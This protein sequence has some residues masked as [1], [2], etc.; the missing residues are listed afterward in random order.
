MAAQL[1]PNMLTSAFQLTK[2][3]HRDVYPAIDPKKLAQLASDKVIL[4]TGAGG[5]IGYAV[6]K[7]WTEVNAKGVVLVGRD[8]KKLSSVA[9]EV[10][11]NTLVAAGDITKEEDV[12][13]IFENAIAKFGTVDVVVNAAGIF[14]Y[15]SIGEFEPSQ[16]W[17]D[18]EINVK[19]TY[20]LAQFLHNFNKDRTATFINLVSI[21]A[22]MTNSGLSS[23]TTSQLAATKLGEHLDLELSNLRV[24]SI[25]PGIV[26]AKAGRGAV[27]DAMTPFAKDQPELTGAFT[28]YLLKP[29]ADVLRGGYVSVNWDVE[30]IRK[31]AEEI[32]EGKLL[33]LGH[34]N[35]KVG[36]DG[37][38]WAQ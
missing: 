12:K 10:E 33:R 9:A 17:A 32:K 8:A 7:T 14:N 37:H 5:G 34:I 31:H 20:I 16:W 4:V 21:G 6:A 18:F 13:A 22:S 38:P 25:H 3:L 19:A 26:E 24:F 35:A 15:G 30:E 36:P 2:A 27:V 23:L 29:E 28:L 1:D 11:G